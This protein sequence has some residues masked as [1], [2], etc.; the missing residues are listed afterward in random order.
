MFVGWARVELHLPDARSLKDKRAV[1]RSILDGAHARMRCAGAEVDHL[2]L[3]QRAA[4]G[5]SVVSNEAGHAQRVIGELV[6]RCET[7]PGAQLLRSIDGVFSEE[8][9]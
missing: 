1:V 4:L 7:A 8:D 6:R 9:A 3:H 5:F 2:E